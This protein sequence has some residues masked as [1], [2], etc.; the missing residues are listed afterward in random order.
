MGSHCIIGYIHFAVEGYKECGVEIFIKSEDL[1]NGV[2]PMSLIII[3]QDGKNII[4]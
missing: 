3:T 4:G 2:N 1:E